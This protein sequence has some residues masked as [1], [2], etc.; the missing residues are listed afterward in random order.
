MSESVERFQRFLEAQK[1]EYG[2]TLPAKVEQAEALWRQGTDLEGLQR[3]GHTIYGAA[4]TYGF[5]DAGKAAR[6]LEDAVQALRAA[7]EGD[8]AP[9]RARVE[10]ALAALRQAVPPA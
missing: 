8:T 5:N 2:R 3:L 1:G 10:A 6:E 4:G 7:A 9:L